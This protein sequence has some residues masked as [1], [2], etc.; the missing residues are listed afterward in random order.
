MRFLRLVLAAQ[1]MARRYYRQRV[2]YLPGFTRFRP[3]LPVMP[4]STSGGSRPS[5]RSRPSHNGSTGPVDAPGTPQAAP[6]GS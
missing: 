1:A 5:D 4:S 2:Q 6:S 3:E